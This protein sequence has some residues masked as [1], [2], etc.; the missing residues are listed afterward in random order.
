VHA[1][2]SCTN[3]SFTLLLDHYSTK[4]LSPDTTFVPFLTSHANRD[5]LYSSKARSLYRLLLENQREIKTEDVLKEQQTRLKQETLTDADEGMIMRLPPISTAIPEH[6]TSSEQINEDLEKYPPI[7]D[8]MG[9][10]WKVSVGS[11][12]VT[13]TCATFLRCGTCDES[14]LFGLL[15][16]NTSPHLLCTESLFTGWSNVRDKYMNHFTSSDHK[17]Q[18]LK[19]GNGFRSDNYKMCPDGVKYVQRK[20]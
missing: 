16:H 9:T 13:C 12:V 20:H 18:T 10:F 4:P 14:K 15:C 8:S 11:T 19:N 6:S 17:R 5:G 2:S 3:A 1:Y 7:S